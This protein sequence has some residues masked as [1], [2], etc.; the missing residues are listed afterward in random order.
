MTGE[1]AGT[2]LF[3]LIAFAGAQTASL[4][5]PPIED[6]VGAPVNA[7]TTLY[8]SLSFGFSLAVAAGV[9]FRISGGLFNPAVS[10]LPDS[11]HGTTADVLLHANLTGEIIQITLALVLVRYIPPIRGAVLIFTQIVAGIAGAAIASAIL[12]GPLS[13][14]TNL[15][16]GTSISRGLF[17]EM[18]LTTF[19]I[20]TVFFL[21]VEKQR[22]TFIAPVGFGLA[23]F[24]AMLGGTYFTGASLNPARSFGP[25]V[26]MA[27]FPGYHWIYWVGPGLGSF[28]SAGFY[29]LMKLLRY[30]RSSA[31]QHGPEIELENGGR[32]E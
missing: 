31:G 22:A 18:F 25:C 27:D 29:G 17:L 21:A 6:R 13:V 10:C 26:V 20:T 28:V 30:E 4:N 32:R 14:G 2:V 16:G 1:F 12:P 19:L 8:I 3:L 9:F 7:V 15:A 23:L 5:S 11:V 24:V